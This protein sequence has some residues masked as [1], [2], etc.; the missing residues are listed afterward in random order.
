M[1]LWELKCFHLDILRRVPFC[2]LE[3][4]QGRGCPARPALNIGS[5]LLGEI[6]VGCIKLRLGQFKYLSNRVKCI[7]W[8][9]SFINCSRILHINSSK[10][11]KQMLGLLLVSMCFV[12]KW[13]LKDEEINMTC[14][15]TK[16]KPKLVNNNHHHLC[17]P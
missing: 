14:D 17:E 15:G 2:W 5:G 4:W 9:C 1:P 16:G 10:R 7:I 6:C 8:L 11:V 12:S 13:I 3:Y